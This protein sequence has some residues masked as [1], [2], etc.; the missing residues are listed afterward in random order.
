MFLWYHDFLLIVYSSGGAGNIKYLRKTNL[1]EFDV[2]LT[3]YHYV[4]Q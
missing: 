3:V 1:D 2:L 4:S